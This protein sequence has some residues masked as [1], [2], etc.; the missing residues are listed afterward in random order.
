MIGV[1]VKLLTGGLLDKVF[2]LYDS[3]LKKEISEAEFRSR[4]EI[5]AQDTEKAVETAWADTA[6]KIAE[7]TQATVRVSPVIQRAWAA[8]MGM[9]FC[10]LM[11]YQVG[12]GAFEIYTGVKWPDPGVSLGWGYS[13][14]MTMVGG[15][16]VAFRK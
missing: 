7:S 5:A 8:G 14:L 3:Y 12:A 10:V 15:Y 6:A 16:A 11:W 4:V 9:Q 2:G 1:I 13:L